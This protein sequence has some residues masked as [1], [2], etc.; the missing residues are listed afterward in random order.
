MC[1]KSEMCASELQHNLQDIFPRIFLKLYDVSSKAFVT[2]A[3]NGCVQ[4][5]V[6]NLREMLVR[7]SVLIQYVVRR[8]CVWYTVVQCKSNY[9]DYMS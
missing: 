2:H 3:V 4:R 6:R 1:C 8:R 5:G 9:I 7:K